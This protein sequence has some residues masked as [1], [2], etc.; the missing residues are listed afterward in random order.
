MRMLTI[1]IDISYHVFQ[2]L[3]R[4]ILSQSPHDNSNLVRGDETAAV[5]IKKFECL[6]KI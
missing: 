1:S 3:G 5:M 4:R 6:S 2:F